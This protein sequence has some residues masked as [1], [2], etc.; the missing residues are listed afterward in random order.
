LTNKKITADGSSYVRACKCK[1]QH[2]T[3][4]SFFLRDDSRSRGGDSLKR[5]PAV[6]QAPPEEEPAPGVEE[7]GAAVAAAAA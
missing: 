6:R 4:P 2:S 3:A 1:R 7:A 5:R